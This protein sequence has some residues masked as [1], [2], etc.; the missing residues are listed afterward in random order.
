M[1]ATPPRDRPA[2][3]GEHRYTSRTEW[4]GNQGVGTVGYRAYSRDHLLTAPGKSASILGSS[5]PAFLGDTSRYN[6]EELLL[7]SLSACHMLWYLH[8]CATAG[9]VVTAYVDEPVGIMQESADG[10]GRFTEV[11]L[12]PIVVIEDPARADEA[13]SLHEKA[14][15]MCFIANSCNFP[16]AHV[17]TIRVRDH[18]VDGGAL[19]N[20]SG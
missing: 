3:A 8:L 2:H 18:E 4:T 1:S 16:V 19:A 6:P 9:V 14:G 10:S 15:A 13:E 11:T 7:A 5:D 12:H 20:G 17:P